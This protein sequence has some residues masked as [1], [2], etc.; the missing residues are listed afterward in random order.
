MMRGSVFG[1]GLVCEKTDVHAVFM[2][3]V[4]HPSCMFAYLE[5]SLLVLS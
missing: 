3:S 5:C 4:P 2:Y 1:P